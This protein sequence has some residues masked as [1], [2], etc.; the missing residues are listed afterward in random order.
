MP[1][2]VHDQRR[3][4]RHLPPA[5]RNP[6][7]QVTN[8]FDVAI[9]VTSVARTARTP[10]RVALARCSRLPRR[11]STSMSPHASITLPLDVGLDRSAPDAVPRGG[12][13]DHFRGTAIAPRSRRPDARRRS[14]PTDR[15]VQ[16]LALTARTR[17]YLCWRAS[18][19]ASGALLARRPQAG[20]PMRRAL[21]IA[22]ASECCGRSQRQHRIRGVVRAQ[23]SGDS[24]ARTW[25]RP[26]RPAP[27]GRARGR[28]DHPN[29]RHGLVV[30]HPAARRHSIAGYIVAAYDAPTGKPRTINASCPASALPRR[31]G[32]DPPPAPGCT[33]SRPVT[34]CGLDPEPTQ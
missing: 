11:L 8:P 16:P 6:P 2:R 33:R 7:A 13:R 22:P 17:S 5:G 10:V 9:R 18:L 15:T 20:L 24:D 32:V 25:P 3:D 29:R 28:D 14:D 26:S 21:A 12:I 34:R 31:A 4:R 30:S 27:P 1:A 19:V 23:S